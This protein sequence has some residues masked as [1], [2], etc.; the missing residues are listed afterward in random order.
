[1]GSS[2]FWL[3]NPGGNTWVKR[4]VWP[5]KSPNP[6]KTSFPTKFPSPTNNSRSSRGLTSHL[7][8]KTAHTRTL[9]HS[10]PKGSNV[11]SQ[12]PSSTNTGTLLATGGRGIFSH[13]RSEGPHITRGPSSSA[14][15]LCLGPT[16]YIRARNLFTLTPG[17]TLPREITGERLLHDLYNCATLAVAQGGTPLTAHTTALSTAV[18]LN[19]STAGAAPPAHKQ[20]APR[21]D[22]NPHP[23]PYL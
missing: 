12:A 16:K 21:A 8:Q 19:D 6:K 5:P 11:T 23:S 22:R 13:T 1:M 10:H 18:R 9:S 7:S 14:G 20:K 3:P 4:N 2:A 15:A 17:R